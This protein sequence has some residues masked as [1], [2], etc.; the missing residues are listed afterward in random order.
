MLFLVAS[1]AESSSNDDFLKPSIAS[2]LLFKRLLF[3]GGSMLQ[4]SVVQILEYFRF[5]VLFILCRC[6]IVTHFVGKGKFNQAA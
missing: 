6:C 2:P 3:I 5:I 4:V 1:I